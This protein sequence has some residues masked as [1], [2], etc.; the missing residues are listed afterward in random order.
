[1]LITAAYASVLIKRILI[2]GESGYSAAVTG[3]CMRT[4]LMMK[5]LMPMANYAPFVEHNA[6][7]Y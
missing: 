2:Q 3:G 4:V 1:M 7:Q 5:I 6:C